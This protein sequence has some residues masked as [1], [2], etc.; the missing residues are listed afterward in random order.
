MQSSIL[1][2]IVTP[3]DVPGRA[4]MCC[5]GSRYKGRA[6][7]V[8]PG[9]LSHQEKHAQPIR[10]HVCLCPLP[11][12]GVSHSEDWLL[13]W[14]IIPVLTCLF[15]NVLRFNKQLDFLSCTSISRFINLKHVS[16]KSSTSQ[17]GKAVFLILPHI[18]SVF[19]F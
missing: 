4:W 11:S 17:G 2:L 18:T 1:C 8:S 16:F 6:I 13:L 15:F 5:L 19:S 10:V 12:L 14:V 9:S 3:R 7:P